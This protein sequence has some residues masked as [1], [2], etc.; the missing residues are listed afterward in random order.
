M[1]GRRVIPGNARQMVTTFYVP[2][3]FSI[4]AASLGMATNTFSPMS[5]GR[6]T[7]GT[8][9]GFTGDPGYGVNRWAGARA[10]LAGAQQ[11]IAAP[12][13]PIYDPLSR[14]LGIGAMPAGQ[15]GM[16][17]TGADAGGLGALAWL[18][19]GQIN[20]LGMGR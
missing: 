7:R 19:Y 6:H 12:V 9:R 20:Q 1:S 15:P 16:P 2:D 14:R 17:S 10:Y 3:Q 5:A 4:Q 8:D 11:N 18:G 13:A